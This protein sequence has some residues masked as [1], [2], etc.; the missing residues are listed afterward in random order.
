MKSGITNPQAQDFWDFPPQLRLLHPSKYDTQNKGRPWGGLSPSSRSG[1]RTTPA[2]RDDDGGPRYLLL[3]C[4]LNEVL[5]HRHASMKEVKE[6]PATFI[7]YFTDMARATAA[8]SPHL[9]QSCGPSH[10]GFPL[11]VLL[12]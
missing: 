7:T 10:M 4:V 1:A 2:Q 8:P 6:R 3:Q 5:G 9:M 11:V 12:P